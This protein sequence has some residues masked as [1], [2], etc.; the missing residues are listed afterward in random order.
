MQLFESGLVFN[1]NVFIKSERAGGTISAM[2]VRA[3]VRGQ[4][5]K[6]TK[7]TRSED[8]KMFGALLIHSATGTLENANLTDAERV[9]LA[10]M[11]VLL[12]AEHISS[13]VFFSCDLNDPP[14]DFIPARTQRT[15]RPFAQVPDLIV[16][17]TLNHLGAVGP[18]PA[19]R[20][21]VKLPN[22]FR[23]DRS[24][25][26]VNDPVMGTPCLYSYPAE[27]ADQVELLRPG[28]VIPAA[29]TPECL[30]FLYRAG[31]IESAADGERARAK[32]RRQ[33]AA[34][35]TALDQ[36]RY[37]VM[38]HLLPPLQ[39]AAIRRY[40][41]ELIAE[42]FLQFGDDEWPNRYFT[43]HDPIGHFFHDQLASLV[44]DIAGQPVKASFSFFASYHPGS[45]LPEHRDREQCEW[46]LSLPID[47]SPETDTLPWPLYLQPPG[48]DHASPT[49]TGVGDGT[50]YYG[51]E[52]THR[53]DALTTADFGS[54]WFLFYVAE[55]FSGSLE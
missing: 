36:D 55:D 31:V 44:S 4:P 27:I 17:P 42:G 18:T 2:T 30:E 35:R 40:Y 29:I 46:A 3:P 8:P 33:R 34:A 10:E 16:N 7:I 41:R 6:I 43:P 1:P 47:Q 22:A 24:W 45:T 51:R 53:R 11:G 9:R 50:L 20:G 13:P 23:T 32:C 21:R 49:I 48:R 52:V 38:P 15:T 28:K 14:I 25:L 54:F 37:I 39:L 5:L 19:M 26:M 12:P